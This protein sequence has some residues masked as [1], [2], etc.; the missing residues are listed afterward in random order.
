MRWLRR[1][2][3]GGAVPP[4]LPPGVWYA[5]GFGIGGGED[6]LGPTEWR[7]T[8]ISDGISSCEPL[9]VEGEIFDFNQTHFSGGTQIYA[10]GLGI[11]DDIQLTYTTNRRVVAGLMLASAVAPAPSADYQ[12]SAN[13]CV[14]LRQDPSAKASVVEC[15][16]SGTELSGGDQSSYVDAD[17]YT[18]VPLQ[19]SKSSTGWGWMVSKYL[20]IWDAGSGEW[21]PLE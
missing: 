4:G 17:G 2:S 13:A 19:D 20:L 3:E 18:W 14:N 9:A 6:M 12:V 1:Y 21:V 15:I 7:A 8:V 16:E 5:I 10:S 11:A